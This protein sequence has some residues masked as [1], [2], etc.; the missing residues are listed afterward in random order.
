[1]SVPRDSRWSDRPAPDPVTGRAPLVP[2]PAADDVRA[3]RAEAARWCADPPQPL[4][5][6]I[7]AD[8]DVALGRALDERDEARRE[9]DRLA[10]RL[11]AVGAIAHGARFRLDPEPDKDI[12]P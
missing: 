5:T 3:L 6:G 1:M 8:L 9:R 11:Q 10:R 4:R 7:V 12:P 2:T